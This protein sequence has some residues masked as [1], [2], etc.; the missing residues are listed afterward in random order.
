MGIGSAMTLTPLREASALG[1]QVAILH[2]T[3]VAAGVYGNLGFKELC[4]I[5]QFVWSEA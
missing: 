1:Y 3:D 4:K 2:S 5:G